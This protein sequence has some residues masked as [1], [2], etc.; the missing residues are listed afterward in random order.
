MAKQLA[1]LLEPH[2]PLFIEEP[3]LSEHLEGIRELSGLTTT[4]IALGERLYSRWD[5]KPFLTPTPCVDILQPDISHVGGIS[6]IRRIA[7]MCEAWD[8]A[9]APHCP[10]GSIA[11]GACFQVAAATP[12]HTMQE[13]SLGIH[14]NR[15]AGE[16]DIDT[17]L[18]DKST[19]GITNGFV[20]LSTKPGLG[21]EIDEEVVRAKSMNSNPWRTGSFFGEDGS[22]REW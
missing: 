13:M 21:I 15:D 9:L 3:L 18:K 7:S 10:L 14:Y 20:E 8:V 19:F 16:E 5:V 17:Y 6:E 1:H 2:R 4:P 12:N 11:L 22:I